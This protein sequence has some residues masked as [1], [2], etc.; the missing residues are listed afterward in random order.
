MADDQ[1]ETDRRECD[2]VLSAEVEHLMTA[3][4]KLETQ[5]EDVV[6]VLDGEERRALD[7]TVS[8]DKKNGMRYKVDML[9]FDSQN[10]GVRA[11]LSRLDRFFIAGIGAAAVIGSAWIASL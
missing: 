11:R 1:R 10:G 5:L 7:G 3:M 9:F 6:T 8:R 2:R 4:P